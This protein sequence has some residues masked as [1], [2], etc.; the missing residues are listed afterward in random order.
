MRF[1]GVLLTALAFTSTWSFALPQSNSFATTSYTTLSQQ[2]SSTT[3]VTSIVTAHP[4]PETTIVVTATSGAGAEDS[5]DTTRTGSSI[6]QDATSFSSSQ[7]TPVPLPSNAPSGN[8]TA[9]SVVLF[10][11]EQC[12]TIGR[13]FGKDGKAFIQD[14]LIEMNDM[15]EWTRD[16]SGVRVY[17][18]IDW[19][20]AAAIEFFGPGYKNIPYRQ[21]IQYNMD[22]LANADYAWLLGNWIHVRCDD[23]AQGC[24]GRTIMYTMHDCEED[25][26]IN[27]CPQYFLKDKLSDVMNTTPRWA[28]YRDN[29]LLYNSRA[30]SWA[31]ELM[32]IS[33]IGHTIAQPDRTYIKDDF[34]HSQGTAFKAYRPIDCKYLS[35]SDRVPIPFT[36]NNP[37]NYAYFAL[38]NYIQK[39]VGYYPSQAIW[40]TLSDPPAPPEVDSAAFAMAANASECTI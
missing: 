9:D 26:Q 13:I 4:S 19:A 14:G 32:H 28:E 23:I 24:S 37:Q 6:T 30:L 40:T 25:N 34:I 27:V 2:S 29:I 11:F 15:I 18:D 16:Y 8:V 1:L 10:G 22:R 39:I 5:T 21:A 35:Y 31:H 17:P 38:A 36:I 33:F 20:S 7:S 3:T 12:D